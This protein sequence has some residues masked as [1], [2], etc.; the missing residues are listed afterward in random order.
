[1]PQLSYCHTTTMRSKQIDNQKQKQRYA[2]KALWRHMGPTSLMGH[3]PE[4]RPRPWGTGPRPGP[5]AMVRP[6]PAKTRPG[7]KTKC[8]ISRKAVVSCCCCCCFHILLRC[9]YVNVPL[10]SLSVYIYIYI[11][12]LSL[13]IY[14]YMCK[15]R[16]H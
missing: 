2:R 14:I 1:M 16:L 3:G 9:L 8:P 15:E 7:N 10:L 11:Y 5:C 12:Y 4:T 6:T 13:Y